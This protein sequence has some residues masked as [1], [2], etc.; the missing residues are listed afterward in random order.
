MKSSKGKRVV[1]KG[2]IKDPLP[3]KGHARRELLKRRQAD[4]EELAETGVEQG[5]LPE[6]YA[7]DESKLDPNNMDNEVRRNLVN[8]EYVSKRDSAYEYC[9]IE[10]TNNMLFTMARNMGWEVVSGEMKEAWEHRDVNGYRRLGDVILMRI[11]KDRY[12]ALKRAEERK[13]AAQEAAVTE[14][15]EELGQRFSRHG[16][17][18]HTNLNTMDPRIRETMEARAASHSLPPAVR[19]EANKS[20]AFDALNAKLRDGTIPGAELPKR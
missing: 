19:T 14:R 2:R 13:V 4:L 7:I 1:A 18:I 9:W 12:L 11:R 8:L 6:A 15:L 5:L 3:E 10:P 16:G 20:L 17:K